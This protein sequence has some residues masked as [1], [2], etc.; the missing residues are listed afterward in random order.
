MSKLKKLI[1]EIHH[2][3]LWQALV[4]Y[5]GAS[6]HLWVQEVPGSNPGAPILYNSLHRK[7]LRR[8]SPVILEAP[9][10][11]RFATLS[12]P[13]HSMTRRLPQTEGVQLPHM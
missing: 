2:R 4:V 5:L 13:A 10:P 8:C 11:D 7:E 9:S 3:S 6:F 12:S 1:T